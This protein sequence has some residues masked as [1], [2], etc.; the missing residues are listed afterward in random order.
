MLNGSIPYH[1]CLRSNPRDEPQAVDR[2]VA[3]LDRDRLDD[4]F[5]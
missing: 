3:A 5:A 2:E 1:S 4:I